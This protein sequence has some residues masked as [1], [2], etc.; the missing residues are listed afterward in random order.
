MDKP[1]GR[2][3]EELDRNL[4]NGTT[5]EAEHLRWHAQ[6][7][8][9]FAVS[10]LPWLA[11]NEGKFCRLPARARNGVREPV[12]ILAQCPSGACVRWRTNSTR[13]AVRAQLADTEWF[14]HMPA[15]GI[16]GLELF[17]GEALRLRPLKPALPALDH[18]DIEAVL[19]KRQSPA[20]FEYHLQLPLYKGLD[21]LEIG[22]DPDAEITAPSPFSHPKPVVF[23]GT[24]ITQGG[25]ANT[26]GADF[27]STIGR[28]LNVEV[29]NLGFSGNG[30]GEPEMA[31]L[32]AEIDAGV[33]V[34]D[35]CNVTGKELA[36]TLPGFLD[37]LRARHPAT[38]ILLKTTTSYP[39]YFHDA[40]ARA[41]IDARRNEMIRGYLQRR[42]AGDPNIHLADS[43]GMMDPLADG[44][45]SDGCHP[46]SHGFQMLAGALAPVIEGLLFSKF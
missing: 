13:I 8:Q 24:S 26:A 10:G 9:P 6:P 22:L 31:E 32:V 34:V 11:E 19:V 39:T 12:W 16:G 37:I 2:R 35:Y 20:W 30:K 23:Y 28:M 18:P 27:V 5:G 44:I 1:A 29:V 15:S 7:S 40:S 45:T 42:D 33:F 4:A 21:R 3:I 38:P 17:G 41:T 43:F 25:C 36:A 14:S 46:T